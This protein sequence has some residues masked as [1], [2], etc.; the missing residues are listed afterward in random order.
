MARMRGEIKTFPDVAS[1]VRIRC[2]D[3]ESD[4]KAQTH[5]VRA[6]ETMANEMANRSAEIDAPLRFGRI[7][8]DSDRPPDTRD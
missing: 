1:E 7:V 6:P 3:A 8:H 4:G 2:N 5:D